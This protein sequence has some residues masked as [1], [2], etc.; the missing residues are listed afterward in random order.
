ME[1]K[2]L[3]RKNMKKPLNST[4]PP[5]KSIPT[6]TS[7]TPINPRVKSVSKESSA[8]D[9]EKYVTLTP[10]F[11]KGCY[12]LATAQMELDLLDDHLATVKK[13]LAMDID[14]TQL[15]KLQR[16][17]KQQKLN[18]RRDAAAAAKKK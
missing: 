15:L 18:V 14:N 11:I 10:S 12:R 17:I 7:T 2:H 13:G 16:S 3:S 9:A 5:S 4:Q 8:T 6:I 1:I